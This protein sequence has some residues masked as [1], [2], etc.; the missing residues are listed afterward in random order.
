MLQ[1]NEIVY[2]KNLIYDERQSLTTINDE[3]IS[4]YWV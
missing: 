1:R 2:Q 3:E 4:F